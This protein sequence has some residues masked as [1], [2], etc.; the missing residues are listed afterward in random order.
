M[1]VLFCLLP[2]GSSPVPLCC[3]DCKRDLL[4]LNNVTENLNIFKFCLFI[5]PK[6]ITECNTLTICKCAIQGHWGHS[7]RSTTLTTIHLCSEFWWHTGPPL[8]LYTHFKWPLFSFIGS[9]R[10]LLI[11]RLSGWIN[12]F[13]RVLSPRRPCSSFTKARGSTD[14]EIYCND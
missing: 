4:L 1:K 5:V 13:Q 10:F 9:S 6:Y 3:H 2:T 11:L 14:R 8:V 12:C 7:H